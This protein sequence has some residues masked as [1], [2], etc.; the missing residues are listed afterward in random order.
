MYELAF[1]DLLAG[2]IDLTP[3]DVAPH[4]PGPCGDLCVPACAT[5]DE[6]HAARAAVDEAAVR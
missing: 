2:V 1:N 5:S 4:A 3:T 6:P